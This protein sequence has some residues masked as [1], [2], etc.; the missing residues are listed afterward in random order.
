[1]EATVLTVEMMVVLGLLAFTV[2]LFV[3]EV[4]RIDLAAILVMVCLGRR[5][6]PAN[7]LIALCHRMDLLALPDGSYCDMN[8]AIDILC[9]EVADFR[10]ED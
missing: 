2:F 4:I 8:R 1:M 7:V 9:G 10:D 6:P 3:S 5:F